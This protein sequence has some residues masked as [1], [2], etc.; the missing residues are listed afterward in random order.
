MRKFRVTLSARKVG[1]LGVWSN[2]AFEVLAENETD[3][4]EAAR[5]KAYESNLEH[6]SMGKAYEV[7]P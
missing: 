2:Y 6:V 4:I 7:K 3:A 5:A 1:A